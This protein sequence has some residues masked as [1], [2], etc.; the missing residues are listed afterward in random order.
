[1]DEGWEEELGQE[2]WIREG[3][4]VPKHSPAVV[5]PGTQPPE[6]KERRAGARLCPG[7][8]TYRCAVYAVEGWTADTEEEGRTFCRR[9][10]RARERDRA[11]AGP[12]GRLSLRTLASITSGHAHR[13]DCMRGAKL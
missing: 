5:R 8:R 11:A 10:H 6:W 1:M 3:R 13:L 4:F 9:G 7:A 2:W 12:P